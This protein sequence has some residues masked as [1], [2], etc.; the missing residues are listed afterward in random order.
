MISPCA[1]KVVNGHHRERYGWSPRLQG[2]GPFSGTGI[3]L[4][5]PISHFKAQRHKAKLGKTHAADRD[6]KQAVRLIGG[7]NFIHQ[8]IAANSGY[9]CLLTQPAIVK[10]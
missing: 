4:P 1:C 6:E 5:W 7:R 10:L 8:N 2:T 3:S 9:Y